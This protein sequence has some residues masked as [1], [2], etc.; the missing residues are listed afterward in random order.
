MMMTLH[1]METETQHFWMK[2]RTTKEVQIIVSLLSKEPKVRFP[3]GV[4]HRVRR[5]MP[6][7]KEN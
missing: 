2:I 5:Q 4:E 7:L 1:L 3:E 6:E